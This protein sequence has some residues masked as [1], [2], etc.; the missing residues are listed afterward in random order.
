[1]QYEEEKR[2]RNEQETRCYAW[3]TYVNVQQMIRMIFENFNEVRWHIR[4]NQQ[5]NKSAA[6]I[7]REIQGAIARKGGHPDP[8][9]RIMIRAKQY[10]FFP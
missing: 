5:R 3:I 4:L 7:Q 10:V 2:I 6:K 9:A 8:H 1:M